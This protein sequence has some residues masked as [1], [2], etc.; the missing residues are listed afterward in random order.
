MWRDTI[1]LQDSETLIRF[2]PVHFT[3]RMIFHCHIAAHS[4]KGMMSFANITGEFDEDEHSS[5]YPISVPTIEYPY[6][7]SIVP[8]PDDEEP[9]TPDNSIDN[10]YPPVP[11]PP[12]T[13]EDTIRTMLPYGITLLLVVAGIAMV[14]FFLWQRKSDKETQFTREEFEILSSEDEELIVN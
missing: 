6:C 3:G 5:K 7:T 10:L 9:D 8:E 14:A 13:K 12:P 11:T 4:D 1:P 2:R